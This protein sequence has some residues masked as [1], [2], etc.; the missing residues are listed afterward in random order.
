MA[1]ANTSSLYNPVLKN[2]VNKNI[3]TALAMTLNNKKS[4]N[5]KSGLHDQCKCFY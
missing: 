2:R 5:N 4:P 1:K 3:S